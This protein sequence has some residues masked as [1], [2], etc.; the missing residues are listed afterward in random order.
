M[1]D[2][3]ATAS[4]DLLGIRSGTDKSRLRHDYLRHYEPS[5]A[6]LRNEPITLLE[7]GVHNGASLDVWESYFPKARIVGVDISPVTKREERDRVQIVIG[8]QADADFL[9]K[10]GAEFKPDIIVDD[11]SHIPE[12]QIIS[13]NALIGHLNHAGQYICEDVGPGLASEFFLEMAPRVFTNQRPHD[14]SSFQVIP[15]AF[16]FKKSPQDAMD[17]KMD[18][19]EQVAATSR[20]PAESLLFLVEYMRRSGVPNSESLRVA[21]MA[22]EHDPSNCWVRLMV[23]QILFDEGDVGEALKEA[24]H[25][26][27][28]VFKISGSIPD[29]IRTHLGRVQAASIA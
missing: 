1:D 15:Q 13:F 14:I 5:I 6:H 7:I 12:H 10:V 19:L 2:F 26:A 24:Q 21:R 23:S 29:P 18:V 25:S 27:E 16:I 28:W 9:H 8:S 20:L 11:G 17:R 3:R 22:S 4:L